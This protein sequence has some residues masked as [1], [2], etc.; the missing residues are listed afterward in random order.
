MT[1][2]PN[3]PQAL[4]EQ[5]EPVNHNQLGTGQES[6]T[7]IH[8]SAAR[9]YWSWQ[10]AFVAVAIVA[11]TS[12]LSYTVGSRNESNDSSTPPL[13]QVAG[14]RN[15]SMPATEAATDAKM[16]YF[17]GGRV[18]LVPAE[19]LRGQ[20]GSAPAWTLTAEGVDR[21]RFITQLAEAIGATGDVRD[22]SWQLG[23]GAL[24]GSGPNAWVST[25]SYG[26]FGAYHPA[27]SPWTCR[28]ATKGGTEPRPLPAED[29]RAS[30]SD[31]TSGSPAGSSSGSTA[32]P[33]PAPAIAP[34]M[35]CNPSTGS[36]PTADTARREARQFLEQVG[37]DLDNS[38]LN[39]TSNG[40]SAT[41][42]Y[43]ATLQGYQL[44]WSI[45]VEVG[46]DGVFSAN[47]LLATARSL[48]AYPIVDAVTAAKRSADPRWSTLGPTPIW[49]GNQNW[50]GGAVPEMLPADDTASNPTTPP[51]TTRNGRPLLEAPV[52]EKVVISAEV[53]LGQFTLP[54]GSSILLPVW[55]F[56]AEDGSRW[57]ML[58]IEDDYVTFTNA[59]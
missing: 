20:S 43:T 34:D 45:S 28:D 26:Y 27:R 47:G 1:N 10:R 4:P 54:D 16:A 57:A 53:S 48:P 13:K 32:E 38:T 15:P 22:E 23:V 2:T 21:K 29:D 44:P 50:R 24:D 40:V 56:R 12:T 36:A 14:L 19:T 7:D 59:E 5:D 9:R 8:S 35:A 51:V 11:L 25:D 42:L 58:A 3:T 55:E 39:V 31:G 17:Y 30:A 52:T 6:S 37:I 33:V 49:E 41:V 18:I 46:S